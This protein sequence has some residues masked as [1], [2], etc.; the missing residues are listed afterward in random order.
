MKDLPLVSVCITTYNHAAFINEALDS[1]LMQ[2]VDFPI[3]ILLGED[4]SS[5]G[6][7]EIC[8][9]YVEKNK[10]KIRLFLHKRENVIHINGRPT[11]RYNFLNNIRNA[12]GKYIALLDGDDYWTDPLKLQKQV[13]FLE[14]NPGYS[15]SFHKTNKMVNR[16]LKTDYLNETTPVTTGFKEISLGN[17]IRTLSVVYRNDFKIPEILTETPVADYVIHVLNAQKG[18]IHFLNEIMGVYRM[19]EGGI[20]SSYKHVRMQEEWVQMLEYLFPILEAEDLSGMKF[21]YYT[22]CKLIAE[23]FAKEN[24]FNN[25]RIYIEKSLRFC[26]DPGLLKLQNALNPGKETSIFKRILKAIKIR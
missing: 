22:M 21:Q 13:S 15:V 12:K 8:I 10:D 9:A 18:N 11:G 16:E 6:T 25:E 7:R 19:H 17:Y 3:E 14:K 1:V 23:S 4:D 26:N 5:D 24:D 2:K 20:W